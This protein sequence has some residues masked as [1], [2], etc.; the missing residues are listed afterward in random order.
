ML[1]AIADYLLAVTPGACSAEKIRGVAWALPVFG[2]E[3]TATAPRLA[4]WRVERK[5]L[6]R[7]M[8]ESV[9]IKLSKIVTELAWTGPPD[10][11]LIGSSA[12]ANLPGHGARRRG[13]DT[14][15]R[16][17][18]FSTRQFSIRRRALVRLCRPEPGIVVLAAEGMARTCIGHHCAHIEASSDATTR[19]HGEAGPDAGVGIVAQHVMDGFIADAGQ[20]GQRRGEERQIA[21]RRRRM[22][23]YASKLLCDGVFSKPNQIVATKMWA[24]ASR[25]TRAPLQSL[26]AGLGM[27]LDG[28]F[29]APP[30]AHAGS[31]SG[32]VLKVGTVAHCSI[33]RHTTLLK[34]AL[35]LNCAWFL[36][37]WFANTIQRPSPGVLHARWSAS[38]LRRSVHLPR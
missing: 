22:R 16:I 25:A 23:S 28:C 20:H 34:E 21:A 5:D 15:R 12:L 4:S 30:R 3:S 19:R 18:R 9:S 35:R 11:S 6:T 24:M 14:R 10:A 36:V 33:F 1:N 2:K 17:R 27:M 38:K 26:Q 37:T 13:Q 7:Q 31:G 8:C 32:A 29:R